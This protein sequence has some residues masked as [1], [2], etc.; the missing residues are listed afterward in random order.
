M[1]KTQARTRKSAPF[2]EDTSAYTGPI[3]ITFNPIRWPST[4]IKEEHCNYVSET[5]LI[6]ETNQDTTQQENNTNLRCKLG[7]F[8]SH[9]GTK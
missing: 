3:K 6:S 9:I 1:E 8:P 2:V 4:G 5:G 7:L